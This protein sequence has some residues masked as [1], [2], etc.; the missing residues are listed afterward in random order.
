MGG[1]AG[2]QVTAAGGAAVLSSL[3]RPL[4][5]DTATAFAG[6]RILVRCWPEEGSKQ[7][8]H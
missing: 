3:N 6:F 7:H 8:S 2:A 5:Q 4:H 1:R